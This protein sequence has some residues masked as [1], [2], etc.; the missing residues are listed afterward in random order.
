MGYQIKTEPVNIIPPAA[1]QAGSLWR[2]ACTESDAGALN[3]NAESD[4][5]SSLIGSL[6]EKLRK[7][8]KTKSGTI[9][10]EI[11]VR[12]LHEFVNNDYTLN[13]SFADDPVSTFSVRGDRAHCDSAAIGFGLSWEIDKSFS[14]A[15]AYDAILSGDHMEHGGTAGIR[16]KW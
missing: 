9:I 12:W 2:N 3:L 15:L 13:A 7:E 16:Y 1:V 5:T 4:R 14:F 6:G 11:R 8:Y 10:P